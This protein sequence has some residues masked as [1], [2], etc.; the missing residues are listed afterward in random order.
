MYPGCLVMY[1]SCMLANELHRALGS[2]GR[3]GLQIEPKNPTVSLTKPHPSESHAPTAFPVVI[4][5]RMK[6]TERGCC[7]SLC[8]PIALSDLSSSPA[9]RQKSH[10]LSCG[11]GVEQGKWP[12][13]RPYCPLRDGSSAFLCACPSTG[14]TDL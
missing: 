9:G 4:H 11:G 5:P 14:D 13:D 10:H 8:G 12:C 2:S 1:G 6:S 7:P 3:D